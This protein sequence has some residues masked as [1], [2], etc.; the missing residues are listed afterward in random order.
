MKADY[1]RLPY[2]DCVGVVLLNASGLVWLGRR[3]PKWEGDVSQSWWQM[4]Q[5][6]IDAGES[7]EQAAFR[8]LE[9]ETGATKAELICECPGWLHYDL[10]AETLGIALKGKYRGQRQK[11]F[12]MRYLGA[13]SDFDISE[14]SG[15]KAEF[16]AWRW[17]PIGEAVDQVVAFKRPVY[18]KV[19]AAFADLCKEKS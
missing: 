9:E 3:I 16:S 14:R 8:E 4:P 13:D 5:G 12:A 2:R 19:A 6:G 17:A 18:E 15:H 11:W 7:P 1:S 10:P